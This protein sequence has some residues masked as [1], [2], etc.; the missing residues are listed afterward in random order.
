MKKILFLLIFAFLLFSTS[1]FAREKLDV[2]LQRVS[3]DVSARIS[4]KTI[5]CVLDFTSKSKEMGE[6][7]RDSLIS[8]FSEN[9]NIR[10]VTRQNM[11]KVNRELDYQYSGYVSDATALSLCQRLGAEE[12]VFGQLDELDNGYILHVKMLDVETGSYALFKKYEIS[13]SSKTEQLLHHAATIYKSS[14]GF[15]AEGNKNSISHVSPA[16]GISFDYGFFRRLSLGV[17]ALVSFDALEKDNTIYTIEPLGFLR[18]YVTS[19]TGEPSAGLFVEG[20]GGAEVILVNDEIKTTASGG[21]S[22]GFRITAGNSYL[23]P[24]LRGGYP[25]LFGAGLGA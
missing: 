23:E 20:Q 6:Y 2:A 12:I 25:Y 7:I 16:A 3:S 10:I 9:P 22:L 17:K 11:D 24:A 21:L 19:P 13:R 5:L 8:S 14:L 1:L 18:W 4:Q 15:V